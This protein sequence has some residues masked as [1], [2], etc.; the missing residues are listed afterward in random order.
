[1]EHLRPEPFKPETW[2]PVTRHLPVDPKRG[3]PVPFITAWNDDGTADWRG[4]DPERQALALRGRLC[5]LCGK[6]MYAWLAF[7]GDAVSTGPGGGYVEP[8][9]H[10][11]CAEVTVAGMCPFVS[12]ERVPW[13]PT[14]DKDVLLC[15]AEKVYTGPKRDWVIAI[16]K[17]YAPELR[18]G[19][20]AAA[21]TLVYIPGKIFRTRRFTYAGDVLTEVP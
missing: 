7:L 10:E 8:P 1:M 9:L 3:L 17:S 20:G 21:E 18:P 15:P 19:H 14:G 13:Q 11:A 2:A 6:T 16:V 12:R 5:A 4:L